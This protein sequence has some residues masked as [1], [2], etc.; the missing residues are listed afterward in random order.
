MPAMLVCDWKPT[1]VLSLLL[2]PFICW[3]AFVVEAE[4]GQFGQLNQLEECNVL[5]QPAAGIGLH[6][7]LCERT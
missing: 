2:M 1:D 6:I 3:I 4:A 5:A 7:S